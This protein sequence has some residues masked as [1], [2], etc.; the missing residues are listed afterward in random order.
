MK[1]ESSVVLRGLKIHT[2]RGDFSLQ[3]CAPK[4]CW[5]VAVCQGLDLAKAHDFVP[6]A[7]VSDLFIWKR[8][9]MY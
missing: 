2:H 8:N 6:G 3:F 7:S 9:S 4:F 5:N 1:K